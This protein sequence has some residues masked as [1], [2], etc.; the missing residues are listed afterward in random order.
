ML[1]LGKHIIAD[2]HGCD[3]AILNDPARLAKAMADACDIIGATVVET[4]SKHFSPYGVTLVFII[5][6]SHLAMHTWPEHGYAAAD[7]FTCGAVDPDGAFEHLRSVLRPS[8]VERSVIAR[9]LTDRLS[10]P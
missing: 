9:G 4:S 7:F 3:H 6:E 10:S 2:F 8:K 5:A 1:A